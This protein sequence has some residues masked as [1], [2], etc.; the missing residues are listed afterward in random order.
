MGGLA[1]LV[2]P[3]AGHAGRT[4]RF[5]QLIASGMITPPVEDGDPLEDCPRIRLPKG[6]AARLIDEDRGE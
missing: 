4:S 3:A 5:D 6:T 1:E 2:P